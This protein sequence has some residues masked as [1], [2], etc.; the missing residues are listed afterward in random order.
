AADIRRV[1]EMNRNCDGKAYLIQFDCT[2][3]R[4]LVKE[5]LRV[6][7]AASLPPGVDLVWTNFTYDQVGF[8]TRGVPVPHG[9]TLALCDGGG[10]YLYVIVAS[11]TGRV[12]VAPVPPSGGYE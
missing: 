7:R 5:G 9:G 8:D 10:R 3:D 4:Y 11:V 1:Q 2:N 6:L 12:R